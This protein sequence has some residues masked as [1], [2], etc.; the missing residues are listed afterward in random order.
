MQTR[1]EALEQRI[2]GASDLGLTPAEIRLLPFL[3][4]HLTIQEIA[5]RLFLS[6]ATVKTHLSSIYGK[7]DATTRSEAVERMEQLGL[8]LNPGGKGREDDGVREQ[9]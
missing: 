4:T 9:S 1:L 7:L 5:A 2:S 3:P 8:G 6:R